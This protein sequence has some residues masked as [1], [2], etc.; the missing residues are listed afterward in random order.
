MAGAASAAPGAV[1]A[2]TGA[3]ESV[4]SVDIEMPR[5]S[6][7]GSTP[8][9][10]EVPDVLA[11]P[12]ELTLLLE[13]RAEDAEGRPRR[14]LLARSVDRVYVER[15]DMAAEWLFIRNPVDPRRVAGRLVDHQARVIV[16]YDESELRMSGIA[17]GWADVAALGARFDLLAG[18][19]PTGRTRQRSG[20]SFVELAPRTGAGPRLWWSEQAAL[21]LSSD[22]GHARELRSLERGADRRRLVDPHQRFPDYEVFDVADYRERRHD[23]GHEPPVVQSTAHQ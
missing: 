1:S 14:E 19:G 16:D 22:P 3:G 18:L 8:V 12:P 21:V 17:R 15:A 11:A 5:R 4:A 13:R 6:P 10:P 9:P 23:G 2:S 20:L 7:P